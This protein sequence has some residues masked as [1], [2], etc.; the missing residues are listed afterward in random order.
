MFQRRIEREIPGEKEVI[1]RT[2]STSISGISHRQDVAILRLR[3]TQRG[4][5]GWDGFKDVGS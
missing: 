4:G 2:G 1:C 3:A 5:A